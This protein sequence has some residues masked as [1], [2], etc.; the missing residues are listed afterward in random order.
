MIRAS[1]R[2]LRRRAGSEA[3]HPL[4]TPLQFLKGVGRGDKLLANLGLH[5]VDHYLPARQ[6]KE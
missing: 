5:T 2:A 3:T 6:R 1:R 4:A